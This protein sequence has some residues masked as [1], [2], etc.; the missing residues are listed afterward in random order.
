L[1]SELYS[2][3]NEE[4]SESSHP[5][6]VLMTSDIH[7]IFPFEYVYFEFSC[8]LSDNKSVGFTSMVAFSLQVSFIENFDHFK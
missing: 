4:Y 6:L 3:I 5:F 1:F 7:N 2:Y 8:F